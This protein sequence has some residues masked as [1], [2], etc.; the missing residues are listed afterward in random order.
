MDSLNAKELPFYFLSYGYDYLDA[1]NMLGIWT[2]GGRH[3]WSNEEFDSLFKEAA[4]MT[5]DP[6]KRSQLFKDAEKV[7]VED[8]PA[9]FIYH[10]TPGWIYKPYLKG[11]ELTPDRT[12]VE[13]WHWPGLEDIGM[14]ALTTY[15]SKDVENYRK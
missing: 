5:G 13:T 3:A 12:G 15:I 14:M 4:P 11:E 8:V 9:A 10:V 2:T 1:S 6:E 7:L